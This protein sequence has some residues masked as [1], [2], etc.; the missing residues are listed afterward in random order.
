MHLVHW[1][2][3]TLPPPPPGYI[4]NPA[5]GEL[6]ISAANRINVKG[7]NSGQTAN[8]LTNKILTRWVTLDMSESL[9]ACMCEGGGGYCF[10]FGTAALSATAGGLIGCCRRT[11]LQAKA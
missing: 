1:L 11:L 2:T 9:G 6:A 8:T 10:A 5:T 4:Y 7:W 3:H